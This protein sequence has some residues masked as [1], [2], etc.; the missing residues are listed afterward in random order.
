ML[1]Y[2][3]MNVCSPVVMYGVFANCF[4]YDRIFGN[5]NVCLHALICVRFGAGCACVLTFGNVNVCL[6]VVIY[7]MYVNCFLYASMFGNINVCVHVLI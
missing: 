6:T 2:C 5:I 3:N 7:G 4:L 1:M